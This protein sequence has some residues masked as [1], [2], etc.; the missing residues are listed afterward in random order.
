MANIFIYR[1]FKFN[2]DD[3]GLVGWVANV[4]LRYF[5]FGTDDDRLFIIWVPPA[6]KMAWEN[7]GQ[8]TQP[9]GNY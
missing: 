8:Q 5:N 4:E 1:A 2:V 9:P 6:L 7:F 3:G